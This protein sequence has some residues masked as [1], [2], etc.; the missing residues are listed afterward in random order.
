[1]KVFLNWLNN[2]WVI[3]IGTSILSGLFVTWV[4]RLFLSKKED[5]EY[6]QRI[7]SANRD[8]I[9]AVRPGISEGT[10]PEVE[11]LFALIEATARRHG[12][13]SSDLYTPAQISEEL[14]KEIMD[15][16]FLSSSKK[17]EYCSQLRPLRT[18]P[19]ETVASEI[20]LLNLKARRQE[21][22]QMM[23]IIFGLTATLATIVSIVKSETPGS[24][25]GVTH[26]IVFVF[27]MSVVA[28]L[29]LALIFGVIKKGKALAEELRKKDATNNKAAPK[30]KSNAAKATE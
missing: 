20:K 10:V 19:P 24:S 16:S 26:N 1:M 9:Y 27:A 21:T 8:V 14:I 11:I 29:L 12:V 5:R 7:A 6:R 4:A 15:T 13:F 17:A 18:T 23:S 25:K 2:A 22:I 3:G 30:E 28:P